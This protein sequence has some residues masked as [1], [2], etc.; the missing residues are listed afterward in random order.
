MLGKLST[1]DNKPGLLEQSSVLSTREQKHAVS[2][3]LGDKENHSVSSVKTLDEK[4]A[5]ATADGFGGQSQN[6]SSL[7]TTDEQ[8][9]S[10][11]FVGGIGQHAVSSK[12]T[13][14][15]QHT[16]SE[17]SGAGEE[18]HLSSASKAVDEKHSVFAS[19]TEGVIPF[20]QSTD[21]ISGD[22]S[23]SRGTVP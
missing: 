11:K 9:S 17:I 5:V 18:K 15:E 4:H 3:K 16:A 22:S 10:S 19:G 2:H 12:Q 23:P 7:S 6:V 14:D 20:K 13:E 1:G 21:Q 8:L